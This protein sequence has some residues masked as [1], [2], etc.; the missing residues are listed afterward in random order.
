MASTYYFPSDILS[1][2]GGGFVYLGAVQENVSIDMQS[3]L[4]KSD[5]T[6]TNTNSTELGGVFLSVPSNIQETTVHNWNLTSGITEEMEGLIGDKMGSTFNTVKK[7]FARSGVNFDQNYLQTYEGTAP[8]TFD[9]DWSFIPQTAAD[10]QQ[11]N[12]ILIKL[13]SWAAPQPTPGR[14]L[15]TQPATWSLDITSGLANVIRFSLMVVTNLSINYSPKG[16]SDF[17]HDG[18]PKQINLSMSFSERQT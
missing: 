6:V 9:F 11:L 8:R 7:T 5:V 13:K 1:H 18:Q 12:E 10:A 2:Q 17:F 15:V 14:I 16:Y 4:S 3:F